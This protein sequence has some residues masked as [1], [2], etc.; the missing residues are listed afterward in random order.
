MSAIAR[1]QLWVQTLTPRTIEQVPELVL[2]YELAILRFESDRGNNET[3]QRLREFQHF[4]SA[5]GKDLHK[6]PS[7]TFQAYLVVEMLMC[8]SVVCMSAH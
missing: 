2:D 8:P 6:R 3:L 1:H 7:N 5:N 4:V